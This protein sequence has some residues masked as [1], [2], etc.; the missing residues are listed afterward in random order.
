MRP[1]QWERVLT[2]HRVPYITVG[3]NVKRG[4]I[5]IRCPFCGSADPSHHMGIDLES[6]W[7][8][9]WRNRAQHSGKSPLRL[10]MKLLGVPY[11]QAREIAGLGND[12]VDPEGFDAVAARVLR[13][14]GDARPATV[15][16]RTLLLDEHFAPITSR[17]RMRRF[18]NYLYQRG[19]SG[20]SR[21]GE[22]VDVLCELYK[23]HAGDGWHWRDRVILPYYQDHKL[24][25]WTG[26]AITPSDRRYQDLDVETSI[27]PPKVTLYNHDAMH[28][29]GKA[30]VIVEGPFDAL[31]LDFYGRAWGVRAVA[32]STNSITD[33]QAFLLQLA[34]TN[35]ESVLVM[36][37]NASIL[38]IADSMRMNQQLRFLP[39]VQSVAVPSGAK[40]AGELTPTQ[41]INWARA[42]N[43]RSERQW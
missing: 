7:W 22:D 23:L 17:G 27:L 10:L 21:A 29:G 5:N 18:W 37:D 4:E 11:G 20:A 25:T 9:C 34:S 3:A 12:Y 24:V 15:E 1:L 13:K 6:G 14:G 43:P 2:E 31:K 41:A 36:M 8:S 35:F 28:D 38:G 32:L 40:D 30:L 16:R 19:F 39:N 42:L 26:R 33:E